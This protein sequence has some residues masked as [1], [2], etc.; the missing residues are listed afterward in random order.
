MRYPDGGGLTAGERS[1]REKVRLQAARM[2]EQG[3]SPVQVAGVLRV[4]AKSAYSWRRS[5]RAGGEPAL[6]SRGPAG[7][8]CKLDEGQL[9]RLRAALDAGPAAFGWTQDQRWTLARVAA[10]IGRLSGIGYTPRGVS[11][12]LHRMGFT[13][14]VAAH[15][16]AERD[17]AKIAA[18]RA[19]TWAKVRGLAAATGAWICFEDEAGQALCPPRARTWGRRGRTPVVTVCGNRA[20]RISVAGLVCLKPEA[21]GRLFYRIR[22]HRRRRK[23]ERQSMS[24][25]DYAAMIAAAHRVLAAPLI[26]IWD[27]LP[28]H[29]SS[30]MRAFTSAHP[31]WLTVI[32]L[33]AYAP[34]LNPVEGLW[35]AMKASLGN[36]A[37][38]TVDQLA[39]TVRSRLRRIQHR[40]EL[41]AGFLAKTELTLRPE[42]PKPRP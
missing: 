22:I 19:V 16:A 21:P 24:E 7:N 29:I 26:V 4:S 41:L 1:R 37:A 10:L 25:A 9:A 23:G 5:W 28:L 35:S 18:W 34:E 38:G 40:P 8:G 13:P 39:D 12:L 33:P 27:N 32:Q 30:R 3:M 42:P 6:A 31:D 15:R 2:F 36:L 11:Y 20:G 14:Q 17:E